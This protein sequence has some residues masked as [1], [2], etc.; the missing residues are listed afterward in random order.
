[1]ISDNQMIMK[2]QNQMMRNYNFETI[3]KS[4]SK[5]LNFIQNSFIDS[6]NTNSIKPEYT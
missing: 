5:R 6:K 2:Y 1:M 3:V 4:M